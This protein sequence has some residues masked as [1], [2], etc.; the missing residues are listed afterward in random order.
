VV[1][2][3]LAV[4]REEARRP[5]ASEVAEVASNYDRFRQAD[6]DVARE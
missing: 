1:E 3:K 5:V 4:G 6:G 2:D